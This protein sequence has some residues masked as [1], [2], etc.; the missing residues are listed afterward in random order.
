[1]FGTGKY[2]KSSIKVNVDEL[3]ENEGLSKI[4]TNTV[5]D[6]TL[7][8]FILDVRDVRS[9]GKHIHDIVHDCRNLRNVICRTHMKPLDSGS[10]IDETQKDFDL[11]FD[12]KDNKFLSLVYRCQGD[13]AFIKELNI[14]C[15][16]IISLRKDSFIDRVFT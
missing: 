11:N 8:I 16:S 1:M 14:D 12:N 15:L 4:D 7:T 6:D 10:I 5:S 9:W 13:I 2:K 3:N